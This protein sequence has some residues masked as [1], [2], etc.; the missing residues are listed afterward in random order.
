[1]KMVIR[2]Q[3][4]TITQLQKNYNYK[5]FSRWTGCPAHAH[6][7]LL[8]RLLAALTMSPHA[9]LCSTAHSTC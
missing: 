4:R 3:K 2:K 9:A 5:T 8:G 6:K 1:M 7:P